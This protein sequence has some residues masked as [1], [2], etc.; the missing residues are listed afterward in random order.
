MNELFDHV[1]SVTKAMVELADFISNGAIS[2]AKVKLAEIGKARAEI[3]IKVEKARVEKAI[4]KKTLAEKTLEL[5]TALALKTMELEITLAEKT[6]E[7]KK[8][9]AE[10][11][12]ELERVKAERPIAAIT[13]RIV[14]NMKLNNLDNTTIS[15]Y[16]EI[17]LP[18]IEKM[19]S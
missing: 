9:I 11:T 8:A 4:A 13:Q 6:L 19:L 15:S 5:E 3:A 16:T 17:S 10:K 12:L 7:L 18:E 2:K 14:F 1:P